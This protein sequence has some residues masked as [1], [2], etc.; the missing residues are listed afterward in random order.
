MFINLLN[1]IFIEF[2]L[3]LKNSTVDKSEYDTSNTRIK[4]D[5]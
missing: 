5:T 1:N 4:V 3:Q 2:T